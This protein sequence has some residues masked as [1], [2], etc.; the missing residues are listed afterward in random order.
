VV[1]LRALYY[2][3]GFTVMLKLIDQKILLVEIAREAATLVMLAGVAYLAG[4]GFKNRFAY[5]LIAFA[6]WDIFYYIWLK[7][8]IDWPA[9]IFDWDIL[10]LIPFTW[11]APVLAPVLCSI[12]MLMLAPLILRSEKPITKTMWIL[13]IIGSSCILYTFLEDYG[14]IIINNGFIHEYLTIMKN[15]GFI[16]IASEYLPTSYNWGLFSVGLTFI[17]ASGVR[18]LLEIRGSSTKS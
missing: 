13:L 8:F 14:R 4:K 16:K 3:D 15:E 9:S 1:Y 2:A 12:A 7:V 5:F 17:L 10:F 11:L 18:L 6:V